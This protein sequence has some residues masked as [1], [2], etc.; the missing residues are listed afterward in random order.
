MT[1]KDYIALAMALKTAKPIK[2]DAPKKYGPYAQWT[3]CVYVV[4]QACQNDN[5]A[6]HRGKFLT[7]C[8]VPNI[9][10]K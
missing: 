2:P 4:M 10:I 9:G 1:K 3:D 6:F 8:G 5:P 7:A